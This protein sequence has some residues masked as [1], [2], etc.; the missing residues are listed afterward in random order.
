M[1]AGREFDIQT[2]D[3]G[4]LTGYVHTERRF[5]IVPQTI[6]GYQMPGSLF[7]P[8][9][10]GKY[11][12]FGISL[13]DAYVR[14]DATQTGASWDMF[15]EAAKY[16]YE[17]EDPRFSFTGELDGIWAKTNWL[18]IGGKIRLGG[19]VLFSDVQFQPEGVLIRI[20]GIRDYINRPHSPVIELSNVTAGT[21]VSGRLKKLENDE[22]YFERMQEYLFQYTKRTFRDA[23]E[24][25]KMLQNAGFENFTE[26]IYPVTVQ[27]M[28]LL[29]GDES[30]QFR[31]VNSKTNPVEISHDV[32]YNSE[33]KKLH[34]PAGIIQHMTLGI[35]SLA[36]SHGVNEYRFWDVSDYLSP[37]LEDAQSYYLYARVEAS[38]TTGIFTLSENAIKM[39]AMPGY[40]HLLLGIL[41]STFEGSRS[42]VDMYG[43]TEVLPGQVRVN[44]V[45]SPDGTQYF[46]MLKKMFHIGDANNFLDYNSSNDGALRLKGVLVQSQSGAE[47]PLG[48]FRGEYNGGTTYYRGDEVTY[49]GSTFRYVSNTPAAGRLPTNTSFWAVVGAK[50]ADG[51][52]GSYTSFVFKQ[53]ATQPATPSG[54]SQIPQGWSDAP[55]GGSSGVTNVSHGTAWAVQPDGMRRSPAIADGGFAKNRIT[56]TTS[57]AGQSVT[58][59]IKVSSEINYDFAAVGLLDNTGLSLTSNYT[60]RISGEMERAVTIHVPTAGT[61]FVE[62]GYGKD[63]SMSSG[64]DCAWYE[65][66]TADMW[67][68]S[69]ATVSFN[70][71]SWVAGGWSV[72]VRVTGEDGL[73]GADG[74]FW[75]YKYRVSATQPST[76]AGLQPSGWYDQ[77]PALTAGNHLWMSYCE[78]NA[79]QTAILWGWSTPVRISGEQGEQGVKGDSPAAVYRGDYSSSAVYYGTSARVDIVKH[80]GYFYVAK[81]TAGNG[82]SGQTPT[83]TAFWTLFGAQFESVATKLL[84]AEYANIGGLVFRNN[85]LESVDGSFYIDGNNNTIVIGKG[86]F[87]GSVATPFIEYGGGFGGTLALLENF[88]YSMN[89]YLGS[90]TIY[91]PSGAQ[92]NGVICRIYNSGMTS[93]EGDIYVRASSGYISQNKYNGFVSQIAVP[94]GCIGIFQAVYRS[95]ISRTEWICL[96]YKEMQS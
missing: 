73:A 72:P 41:N 81:T 2:N 14:D 32:T 33:T 69:K 18:E 30:L 1:L 19:Y 61:H 28:Q 12:I 46:D 82:F 34:S 15:S 79:T 68:M 5:K 43:F 84:L 78:K 49:Q 13:P 74:K 37:P 48:V 96:N 10:G 7:T 50:G 9:V 77:P 29:V 55:A 64:A 65:V 57:A 63:G 8:A 44:R 71:T 83:N 51:Q 47:E 89:A 92:Y 22:A 26:A 11:A 25:A 42:Y 67:W 4:T 80:N 70:G 95:G 35:D 94:I 62:V 36:P 90:Q 52:N 86:I 87:N 53:S 40:Y 3:D 56:F 31:F 6:D 39:N 66:V 24:T 59:R 75:D 20:K 88:N 21:G 23:T 45:I 91:L 85:R 54:T 58:V 93:N 16:L 76:P 60:D 27:T 17:H 38:G